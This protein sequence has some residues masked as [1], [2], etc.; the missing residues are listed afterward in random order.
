MS[1]VRTVVVEREMAHAPEKI[2]RALTQ[3]HLIQEWLMQSDFA[4]DLG[5][6]FQF[7]AEWGAVECKVLEV[8]PKKRLA[9]SWE[10]YG[11]ESVVTWTLEPTANGTLLRM[12]QKGFKPD[13]NQAFHGA[14]HGWQNFFNQ[15]ENVLAQPKQE[16]AQ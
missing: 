13:Q 9:Y 7:K 14:R 5:H 12:E 6:K 10:A 2:W 15:L 8:E 3:P 1:D 16:E 11:L 4:P